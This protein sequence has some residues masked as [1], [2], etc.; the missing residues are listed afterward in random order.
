MLNRLADTVDGA[1]VRL[2]DVLLLVARLIL[3]IYFAEAGFDKLGSGYA[4]AAQLMETKGIPSLLLPLVIALELGG[5]LFLAAGFLTRLTALALG[6]FTVAADLIFNT[7][8]GTVAGHFLVQAELAIVA[9]FIA[10]MAVGAGR[11]SVDG[12]RTRAHRRMLPIA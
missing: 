10:L 4:E 5:A 2:A 11:W 6:A 8:T 12:W 3:A 7:G 9:G 1:F